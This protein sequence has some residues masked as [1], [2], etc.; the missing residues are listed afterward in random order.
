MVDFRRS[1]IDSKIDSKLIQKRV[2]ANLPSR[3]SHTPSRRTPTVPRLL[4]M[5]LTRQAEPPQS[6]K[7]LLYVLYAL[8]GIEAR[9]RRY[10]S[11]PGIEAVPRLLAICAICAIW[12]LHAKPLNPHSLRAPCYM[13]SAT[14]CASNP[15]WARILLRR[16]LRPP[17]TCPPFCQPGRCLA[18]RDRSPSVGCKV[19]PLRGE[20]SI[21]PLNVSMQDTA[22]VAIGKKR[23]TR[24][25]PNNQPCA[26]QAS[27]GARAQH[28]TSF[29]AG[30]SALGFQCRFP[31]PTHN[32]KN[33]FPCTTCQ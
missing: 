12:V 1:N 3:A 13:C 27:A 29:H 7:S 10:R 21:H 25:S 17:K 16:L 8:Y 6:P 24:G 15:F 28:V 26:L 4:Y 9:Y 32:S 22:V 2:Y 23:N 33:V 11:L 18:V 14:A 19:E 30:T 31:F 5:G 20:E